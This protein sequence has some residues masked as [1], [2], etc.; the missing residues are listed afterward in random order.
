MEPYEAGSTRIGCI[1]RCYDRGLEPV[2]PLSLFAEVHRGVNEN[3]F[4]IRAR[5]WHDVSAYAGLNGF[6]FLSAATLARCPKCSLLQLVFL[7]VENPNYVSA[8]CS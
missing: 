3:V 8:K 1:T 6:L 7:F 5:I 4:S 2:C